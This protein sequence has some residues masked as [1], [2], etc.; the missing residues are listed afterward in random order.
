[1]AVVKGALQA[2]G[3]IK[4]LTFY[5]R[6][7]S[8]KVI[9]RTKGGASKNRITKGPEFESLRKHQIEWGV[10]VHFA[11]M[12]KATMGDIVR[13]GDYNASPVITGIGKKLMGLDKQSEIG[14]RSL[15]L[16]AYRA[17]LD[18]LELN[19]KYPF[20]TLL[21]VMPVYVVD[22][23]RLRATIDFPSIN[24]SMSLNNYRNM[25]YFRLHATLGCVADRRC[26][27]QMLFD[28]YE[29]ANESLDGLFAGYTSPWFSANDI[30]PEQNIAL[31]L[32]EAYVEHDKSEVSLLLSVGVEFGN[33]GFGGEIVPVKHAGS[34]KVVSC[35]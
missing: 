22:K 34:G 15:N 4:G 7:D 20:N 1:M 29:P 3:S 30:I 33:V 24:T 9:M 18:N 23:E 19:R 35:V 10:C 21:R 26:S 6:S 14:R 16:S 12:V 31:Q 5:K 28:N 8:E 11:R 2:S 27:A 25:P 32:S 13:L 17:P